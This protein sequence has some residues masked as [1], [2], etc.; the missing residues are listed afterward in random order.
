MLCT[1][2]ENPISDARGYI[3]IF[4]LSLQVSHKPRGAASENSRLQKIVSR[5]GD[6]Q[7]GVGDEIPASAAGRAGV[8]DEIPTSRQD[9]NVKAVSFTTNLHTIFF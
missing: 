5:C 2:G 4:Q 8:G 9:T 3:L 7:A 1:S 6:G